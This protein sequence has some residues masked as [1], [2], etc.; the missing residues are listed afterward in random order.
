MTMSAPAWAIFDSDGGPTAKGEPLAD[1][2]YYAFEGGQFLW[3]GLSIGFKRSVS[4]PG[5]AE[6]VSRSPLL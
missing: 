2:L 5:R 1:G 3:P 6:P 4:V